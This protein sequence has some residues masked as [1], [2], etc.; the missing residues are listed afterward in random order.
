MLEAVSVAR[1]VISS[2]KGYANSNII[3]RGID[4]L[5]KQEKELRRE[6]EQWIEWRLAGERNENADKKIKNSIG[7]GR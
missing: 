6:L 1:L 5:G 4:T 3:N 2:I 7:S